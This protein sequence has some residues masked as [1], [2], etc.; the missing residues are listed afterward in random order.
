VARSSDF[1]GY[2]SELALADV[3]ERYDLE[4]DDAG[5]VVLRTVREP[6]P[7]P[8]QLR[9]A[10]AVVVALD[11]AESHIPNIRRDWPRAAGRARRVGRAQLAPAACTQAAAA[12]ARGRGAERHELNRADRA[13][14]ARAGD[15]T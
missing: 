4:P 2:L 6:W 9:V 1:D 15:R 12:R 11:V 14:S 13:S 7:F 5:K 3:V 8:A 10:P